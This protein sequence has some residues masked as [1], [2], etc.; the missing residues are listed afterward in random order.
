[1]PA[2][3]QIV[4][5]KIIGTRNVEAQGR[6]KPITQRWVDISVTLK[7]L[8]TSKTIYIISSIRRLNYDVGSKT[9]RI[10]LHEP[11]STE[12][13]KPIHIF[14][15]STTPLAPGAVIDLELS[16]P[17]QINRIVR[18]KEGKLEF[19]TLD[20]SDVQH[21]VVTASHSA[22]DF[23]PVPGDSPAELK[24]RLHSWGKTVERK[25]KISK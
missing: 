12:E 17:Q 22:T 15:P 20:I 3:L 11:E 8:S 9:L 1:M 4:D 21:V 18:P 19:E 2:D 6:E 13:F 16:V 10:G 24:R 5:A 25:I 7:N 14:P 23:R